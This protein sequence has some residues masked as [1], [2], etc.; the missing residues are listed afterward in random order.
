MDAMTPRGNMTLNAAYHH[1]AWR[2]N[3][4]T[5]YAFATK[6]W[7]PIAFNLGW[8]SP[9]GDQLSFATS[10]NPQTELL[11]LTTLSLGWRPKKDWSFKLN[12]SYDPPAAAWRQ[13]DFLASLKQPLGEKLAVSLNTRYDFFR[14]SWTQSQVALDYNWHCRTLTFGYDWTREEVSLTIL[15]NA[16]PQHPLKLAYSEGGFYYTP[17]FILP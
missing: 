15:I 17:P 3:L 2:A 12:T 16:F 6:I 10:Y 1:E 11:G 8:F 9:D 14:E 4:S 5:N 7:D 13:L